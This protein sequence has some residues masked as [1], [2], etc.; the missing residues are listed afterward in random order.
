MPLDPKEFPPSQWEIIGLTDFKKH[1]RSWLDFAERIHP[2][3]IV[4]TCNRKPY[5]VLLSKAEYDLLK[6]RAGEADEDD[7]KA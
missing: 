7:S 6:R 1:T 2:K 3:K 5:R 4:I